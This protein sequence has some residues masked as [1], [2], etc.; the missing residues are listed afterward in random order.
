[1]YYDHHTWT[2]LFLC[3]FCWSCASLR[4]QL[5]PNS[6]TCAG[7]PQNS[8]VP[9]YGLPSG[10]Q[11]QSRA[12]QIAQADLE[13]E[14]HVDPKTAARIRELHALKQQAVQR[15]DYDEAKQIKESIERVRQLGQ[16]IA[17]L[18]AYKAVRAPKALLLTCAIPRR[19]R[20]PSA[21]FSCKS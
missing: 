14:L 8:G 20:R 13:L 10:T 15:E 5:I 12:A 4:H 18:E 6:V 19:A 9:S 21:S 1:M 17:Q 16:K 7:E 3:I 11:Y 2:E